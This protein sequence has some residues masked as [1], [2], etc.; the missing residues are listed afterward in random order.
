MGFIPSEDGYY[1]LRMFDDITLYKCLTK[2]GKIHT[3]SAIKIQ[4]WWRKIK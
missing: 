2:K 1:L 3:M 4:K